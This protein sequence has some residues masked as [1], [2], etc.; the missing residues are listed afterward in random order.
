METPMQNEDAV[1][2]IFFLLSL[3]G[4]GIALLYALARAWTEALSKRPRLRGLAM[5]PANRKSFIEMERR[6]SERDGRQVV[7]RTTA[8]SE[9][10]HR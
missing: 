2:V 6:G 1:R 7:I 8:N 9:D 5:T 10:N 3:F 4:F